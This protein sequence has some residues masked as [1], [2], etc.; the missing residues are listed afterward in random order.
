MLT[1]WSCVT[2]EPSVLSVVPSQP[3]ASLMLVDE[4]RVAVQTG[5]Q[6]QRLADVDRRIR[7]LRQLLA[8]RRLVLEVRRSRSGSSAGT[9]SRSGTA[10]S[11]TTVI[12]AFRSRSGHPSDHVHERVEHRVEG[13][14][15]LGRGFVRLLELDHVRHL[16]V[17][18]D[19]GLRVP[20]RIEALNRLSAG[21]C[22]GSVRLSRRHRAARS[23]CCRRRRHRS[24]R[25]PCRRAAARCSPSSGP[26]PAAPAA[27]ALGLPDDQRR[28]GQRRRA[29]CRRR[30]PGHRCRRNRPAW[31]RAASR[32]RRSHRTPAPAA[33][34]CRWA[35][36]R[37]G[38]RTVGVGGDRRGRVA[39]A[40]RG[41]QRGL[42]RGLQR[43]GTA[44]ARPV[45]ARDRNRVDRAAVERDTE[46][47]RA[48]PRSGSARGRRSSP[49][50][51]LI[52]PFT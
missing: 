8:G 17:G 19:P 36:S 27:T 4:L 29:R 6:L 1:C 47:Q 25:S 14:D 46:L 30:T 44:G 38:E 9:G 49:R 26:L 15:E 33:R 48:R 2:I 12:A 50:S 31:C 32:S 22:C 3:S 39:R 45:G 28:H 7:R 21:C 16:F 35:R 43:G 18:V 52:A 5:A 51:M 34:A 40:D 11:D 41:V 37:Y 13:D 42:Q 20:G 23:S 10:R 24:W